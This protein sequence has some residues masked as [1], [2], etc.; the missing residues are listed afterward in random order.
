MK[1]NFF[2]KNDKIQNSES[3]K[4]NNEEM[5]SVEGGGGVFAIVRRSD[6]TYD[7]IVAPQR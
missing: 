1:T 7:V 2:M 6:G 5:K 4:L 3:T